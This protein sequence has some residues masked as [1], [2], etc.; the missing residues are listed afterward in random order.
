MNLLEACRETSLEIMSKQD[1][2]HDWHHIKRVIGWANQIMRTLP[3]GTYDR[4]LVICGCLLHD[5]AD[6][7]YTGEKDLDKVLWRLPKDYEKMDKLK[8]II[9]RTSW[10]VQLQEG[11]KEVFQELQIARDSDRLDALGKYGILRAFAVAAKRGTP[12]VLPTTPCFGTEVGIG[13]EDGSLVGHFYAKLFHIPSKLYFDFS[14][15]EASKM[16]DDM[17]VFVLEAFE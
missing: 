8:E 4:E 5:V 17:R 15:E 3:D 6:H 10:T 13:Q 1:V 11:D 2:S 14:K 7:K 9:E 12:L 16:M